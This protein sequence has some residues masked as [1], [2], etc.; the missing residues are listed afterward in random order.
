MSAAERTKQ[1]LM[2]VG[3]LTVVGAL[4]MIGV[5]VYLWW[6][7][8]GDGE[9]FEADAD[10]EPETDVEADVDTGIGDEVGADTVDDGE[11]SGASR[12]VVTD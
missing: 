1:A 11:S 3:L 12:D 7:A 8:R 5:V 2:L 4:A 6:D 9:E 10:F